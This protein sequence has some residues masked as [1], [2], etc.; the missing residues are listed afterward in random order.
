MGEYKSLL[1]KV[2]DHKIATGII[3]LFHFVGLVGILSPYSELFLALT[4][5]N[6][7]LSTAM[8]TVTHNRPDRRLL[9]FCM[10]CYA[11]GFISEFL[12]VQFGL[13]FGDYSYGWVLG[14]KVSG[15]PLVIG[16]NWLI[17]IYS[18]AS[19][20]SLFKVPKWLRVILIATLAVFLDF[21]IEPVAIK[22]DFWSWQQV[23]VPIENY[24]G[25]F[26]I[27]AILAFTLVYLKL[28]T[29]SV[30]GRSLYLAQLVFFILLG[31][32]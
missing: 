15:V 4:P 1:L 29:N 18:S 28:D 24:I 10:V 11:V 26:G 27:S 9:I 22:Y 25:W 8:I 12:G 19:I 7:L 17:V 3:I 21:F 31:V 13:I 23:S 5:F 2:A 30:T 16:F 20:S 6:L 32:L 14:P